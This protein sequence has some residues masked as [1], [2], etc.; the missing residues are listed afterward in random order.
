MKV[1]RPIGL[2]SAVSACRNKLKM[3]SAAQ[4]GVLKSIR[5]LEPTRTRL[6]SFL[7]N[8]Q[9]AASI[10]GDITGDLTLALLQVVKADTQAFAH[11]L[12]LMLD[13]ISV[14]SLDDYTMNRHVRR[15]L[16]A[17]Y[18]IA[19]SAIGQ[20]VERFANFL[21]GAE[22]SDEASKTVQAIQQDIVTSERLLYERYSGLRADLT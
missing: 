18:D 16:M 14:D 1:A 2:D 20:S 4:A 12:D 17:K 5:T 15:K 6:V 9:S 11:H 22:L 13:E 8:A 21:C 7:S 19:T 3:F 10:S